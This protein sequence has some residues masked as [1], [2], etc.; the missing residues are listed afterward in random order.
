MRRSEGMSKQ[1]IE[2]TPFVAWLDLL[3]GSKARAWRGRTGSAGPIVSG[4]S[5]SYR[6]DPR[7]RDLLALKD[8]GS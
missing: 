6:G 8:K 4:Y 2:P 1:A 3:D 7:D 5:L